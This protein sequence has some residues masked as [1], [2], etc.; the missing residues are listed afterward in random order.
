MWAKPLKGV[1]RGLALRSP[2]PP[3]S[4]R[5]GS[6]K[7]SHLKEQG[8]AFPG[9]MQSSRGTSREVECWRPAWLTPLG[10]KDR[11]LLM[12]ATGH[13]SQAERRVESK[14]R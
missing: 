9:G 4:G 11:D 6:G 2:L 5:V 3:G 1:Q 10:A 8:M 13:S 12:K 14:S 7:G